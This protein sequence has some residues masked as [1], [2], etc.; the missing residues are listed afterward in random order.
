[1]PINEIEDDDFDALLAEKRHK[2]VTGALKSVALSLQKETHMEVVSAIEKQTKV[3]ERFVES[4][5]KIENKPNGDVRLEVN[6]AQVVQSISEMG[7]SILE[8]LKELK[9]SLNK[10]SQ[11]KQWEFKVIRG[12][13]G[14]IEKI[15]ASQ[16]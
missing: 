14:V 13:G 11:P 2:E 16:I 10:T 7:Q 15:T 8:G 4:I 9:E 3:V 12:Y 6:Q 5:S 1:M